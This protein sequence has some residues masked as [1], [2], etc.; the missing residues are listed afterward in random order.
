VIAATNRDLGKDVAE[1]KFREDLFHRLNV[2]NLES[3][4]LRDRK[5]DIPAL[6]QYLLR[7]SVDKNKRMVNGLSP[8]ALQ[9][10]LAYSWPGNV[11]ELENAM[12]GAVAM[13]VSDWV[14]PED[15]PESLLE[16]VPRDSGARYHNSVGQAK[17]D[18]A[19][20]ELLVAAG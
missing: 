13:G 20:S 5:E 17:C 1:G 8:E 4:A 3:P 7:R 18:G 6:A 11:R 10:I 16:T 15:L 19:A 9:I 14:L 12:E 2:V